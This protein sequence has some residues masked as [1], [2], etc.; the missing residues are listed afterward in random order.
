M[1]IVAALG[2]GCGNSNNGGQ[3]VTIK[4]GNITDVTGS[5]SP[6]CIPAT[7]GL[8][9]AVKY[10]N[11]NNLVPGA[12]L[13]VF[14]WDTQYDAA[15][16]IPGYEWLKSKGIVTAL[17]VMPF[18]WD[19]LPAFL[20]RDKFV[21][22]TGGAT[23][24]MLANPGW[25]F[26]TEACQ[27]YEIRALLEW[28]SDT[29]WNY[30]Q[31]GRKPKIGSVGWDESH[32]HSMAKAMQSYCQAHPDKFQWVGSAYEP[33]GSMMW[34]G[35]IQVVK[36][37]DYI[38][39]PC[40][41]TG[42]T[43]F[44]QAFRGAGYTSTF[45]SSLSD[46]AFMGLILKSIGWKGID[47]MLTVLGCGSWTDTN[48]MMDLCKQLLRENHA[49]SAES[50]ISSGDTAYMTS[51]FA[52]YLMCETIAKTVEK[53]GAKSF[54]G[55][56]LYDTAI[57]MSVQYEGYPVWGWTQNLHYAWHDTAIYE[58]QASNSAWVRI[59]DSLPVIP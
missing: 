48:P 42:I 21:L 43:S 52:D 6:A 34:T 30:T 36:D 5:A 45:L 47:G 37:C 40:I 23:E 7:W 4:I 8:L 27:F 19:S 13:E 22:F 57:G 28:I 33:M 1:L 26:D 12:K 16:G 29:G 56:A 38:Y 53:V 46:T 51:F 2:L 49:D 32:E 25:S 50:I 3:N 10:F 15:R 39:I 55:Q 9:D 58:A 11:D 20:E 44:A 59:S 24:A 54:N 18:T 31:E 14:T 17:S 41:S 35:E